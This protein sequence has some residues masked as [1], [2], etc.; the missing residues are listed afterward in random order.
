[1]SLYGLAETALKC[2]GRFKLARVILHVII[3]FFL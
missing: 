2:Y 1:M 3:I